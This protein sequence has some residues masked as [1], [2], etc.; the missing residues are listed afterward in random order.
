[1]FQTW[2]FPIWLGWVGFVNAIVFLVGSYAVATTSSAFGGLV[3]AGFIIV[4]I[5]IVVLSV[6]MFRAKEPVPASV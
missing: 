1:M 6:I 4:S 3:L 5:W 2:V